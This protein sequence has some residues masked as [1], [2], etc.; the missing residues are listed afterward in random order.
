MVRVFPSYPIESDLSKPSGWVRVRASVGEAGRV[1]SPFVLCAEPPG[2][3]DARAL[4][5]LSSWDLE[6]QP[7]IQ[8][9]FKFFE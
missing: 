8:V 9:V 3:F 7:E 1:Q 2:K 4:R 6:P 5:L